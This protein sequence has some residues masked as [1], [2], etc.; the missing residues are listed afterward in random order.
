MYIEFLPENLYLLGEFFLLLLR[1]LGRLDPAESVEE[2]EEGDHHVDE[3]DQ[4]EQRV[5][6]RW[7][8]AH[9]RWTIR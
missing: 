3:D 6:D 7:H 1:Q 9:H 4:R 5:R 2:V 8:W